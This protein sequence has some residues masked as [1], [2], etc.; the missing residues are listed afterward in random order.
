M[1]LFEGIVVALLMLALMLVRKK[2]EGVIWKQYHDIKAA[3]ILK[4][5]NH[6]DEINRV[7]VPPREAPIAP[8]KSAL[9]LKEDGTLYALGEKLDINSV[10]LALLRGTY[11]EMWPVKTEE[12]KEEEK[13]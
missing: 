12:P 4:R 1:T 10:D 2:V 8:Y 7:D 11:K 6:I 3:E 13:K 9:E 5:R